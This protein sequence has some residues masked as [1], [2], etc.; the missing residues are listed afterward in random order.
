M[1][2]FNK[3]L[4]NKTKKNSFV[5]KTALLGKKATGLTK[6]LKRFTQSGAD[7]TGTSPEGTNIDFLSSKQK[8]Y[9]N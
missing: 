3:L 6:M 9:Q 1:N 2:N 8:L 7:Q 5:P 4:T